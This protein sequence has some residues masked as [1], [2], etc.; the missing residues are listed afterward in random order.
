[1][2][3]R[4]L[5]NTRSGLQTYHDGAMREIGTTQTTVETGR[6]YDVRIEVKGRQIR[7]FLDGKL[8]TEV[9]DTR[10][11][12]HRLSIPPPAGIRRRGMCS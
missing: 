3:R 4:R 5:G 12:R 2:E 6:W 9:M 10:P 1:M 11:R 8:V 7:C